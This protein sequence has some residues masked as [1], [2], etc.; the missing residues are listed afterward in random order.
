MPVSTIE[1][2]CC[3]CGKKFLREKKL[4][5][6]AIKRGQSNFFCTRAHSI[7][8]SSGKEQ[9]DAIT[10]EDAHLI[11]E[12]FAEDKK[13]WSI[14]KLATNFNISFNSVV[15]ILAGNSHKDAG[16]PITDHPKSGLTDDEKSRVKAAIYYNDEVLG[17]EKLT[18]ARLAYLLGVSAV[19]IYRVKQGLWPN[20]PWPG[21]KPKTTRRPRNKK[22]LTYEEAV[23]IKAFFAKGMGI[24]TMQ[25][26]IRRSPK[27]LAEVRDGLLFPEAPWP[28][29]FDKEKLR[30]GLDWC[31]DK[32]N[33]NKTRQHHATA[34]P[35]IL[36]GPQF[37]NWFY[38]ISSSEEYDG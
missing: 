23:R 33:V 4:Y 29:N 2:K 16:G 6:S 26:V 27:T 8:Y 25:R 24:A 21:E 31:K 5:N 11:R 3:Y 13:K 19:T 37:D 35:V 15:Q 28:E 34:K 38:G 7:Y 1:L 9:S 20:I 17:E 14:T 12:L 22:S 36:R 10:P 18:V 32:V 30:V